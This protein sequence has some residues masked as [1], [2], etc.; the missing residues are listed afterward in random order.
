MAS[1]ALY[2]GIM[3]IIA[4]IAIGISVIAYNRHLD[5]VTKGEVHDTHSPIPEP[6]STTGIVYKIILMVIVILI[7]FSVGTMS[8][9]ISN[10]NHRINQL[11]ND[12]RTLTYKVE[13]LSYE[14]E[15][16]DRMIS[17][18]EYEVSDPVDDMVNV[19]LKLWIRE[20]TDDT[21]V[22]MDIAGRNIELEGN[23][24]G[25]FTCNF[26]VSIFENCS[27]PM[28]SITGNGK[29]VGET[30][31]FPDYLFWD[32]I[33]FPMM[34]CQFESKPGLTGMKTS[35]SY[36]YD[37]YPGDNIE[38][39][40]VTYLSEGRELKT[41]D[42]T[43]QAISNETITLDSGLDIGDDLTFRVEIVTKNGYRVVEQHLMIFEAKD[44]PEDY[45]Y[46]RIYDMDG[47]LLWEN[48]K[49]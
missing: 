4:A 29:T 22:T 28:V 26:S 33:P 23:G 27:L 37:M 49:L 17:S 38:S 7:Y 48:D 42:I 35:G 39:V 36:S 45:E 25:L 11:E 41:M 32:Y 24:N 46:E 40:T 13:D 20:Y 6:R 9:T 5:K 21:T 16:K 31:E 18:F 10:M 19:D 30:I 3:I 43:S 14:L 1:L 34:T 12:V 47:N 8:G 2:I 44:Y 15:M